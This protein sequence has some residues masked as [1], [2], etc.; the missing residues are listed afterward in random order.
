MP[1]NRVMLTGACPKSLL[2]RVLKVFVMR[3]KFGAYFHLF[4]SFTVVESA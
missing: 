2:I 1:L 3:E 4:S